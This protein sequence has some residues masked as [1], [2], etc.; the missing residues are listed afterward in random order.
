MNKF[1]IVFGLISAYLVVALAANQNQAVFAIVKQNHESSLSKLSNDQRSDL[2]QFKLDLSKVK[3]VYVEDPFAQIPDEVLTK[4]VVKYLKTKVG[5]YQS[6]AVSE[7]TF[8]GECNKYLV[9][10]CEALR[11]SFKL[12]MALYYARA[13]DKDFVAALKTQYAKEYD[14]LETAGV[15]ESLIK[16]TSSICSKSYNYMV[17]KK[18]HVLGKLKTCF[19]SC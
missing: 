2:K 1:L 6:D 16:T 9:N 7:E 10:P 18:S 13:Q 14:S 8:V 3:K 11:S 5:L 15:C 4:T 12:S 17:N 19:G